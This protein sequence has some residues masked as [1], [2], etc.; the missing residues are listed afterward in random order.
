MR[1]GVRIMCAL[2]PQADAQATLMHTN[3]N[4]FICRG[5]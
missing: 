3:Y 2:M 4:Y 1:D 5:G